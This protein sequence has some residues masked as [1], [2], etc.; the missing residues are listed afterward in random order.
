MCIVNPAI[1]DAILADCCSGDYG[2]IPFLVCNINQRV[3]N[4]VWAFLN[5]NGTI[6]GTA[7][8]R[9]LGDKFHRWRGF[10]STTILG[11]FQ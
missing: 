11:F 6:N 3:T 9:V 4:I 2:T 1:W 7:L 5:L 10:I 8:T